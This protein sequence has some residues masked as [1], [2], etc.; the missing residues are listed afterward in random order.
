MAFKRLRTQQGT[1]LHRIYV[2]LDNSRRSPIVRSTGN[3]IN[4]EAFW[5]VSVCLDI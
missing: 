2:P 5:Q 4:S 3:K 1:P